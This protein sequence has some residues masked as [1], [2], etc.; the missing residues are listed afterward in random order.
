VATGQERLALRNVQGVNYD[1]QPGGG[2]VVQRIAG[3]G[4]EEHDSPVDVAARRTT[5]SAAHKNGVLGLARPPTR[6]F[7][8]ASQDFTIKLWSFPHA[9]NWPPY[10]T[11]TG[12]SVAYS[13]TAKRCFGKLGQPQDLQADD[14]T[15]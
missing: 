5:P 10:G 15:W 7:A 14:G 13:P 6:S 12:E 3:R 11:R 9:R 4:P 8:S 2:V 1:G